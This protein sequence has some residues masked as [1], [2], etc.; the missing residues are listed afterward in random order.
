MQ[1]ETTH[2]RTHKLPLIYQ[3]GW[4]LS[5][6]ALLSRATDVVFKTNQLFTYAVWGEEKVIITWIQMKAVFIQTKLIFY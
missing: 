1:Q 6:L 2:W 4:F 3:Y 5:Q